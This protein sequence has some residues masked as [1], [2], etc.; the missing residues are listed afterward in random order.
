MRHDGQTIIQ[1]VK[2]REEDWGK[3]RLVEDFRRLYQ[4]I[5]Y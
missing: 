3:S 5:K 4:K 1:P 2:F